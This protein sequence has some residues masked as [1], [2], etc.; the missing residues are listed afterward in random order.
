MAKPKHIA[1]EDILSME[2]YAAIRK[3]KAREITEIKRSRR[4]AVGPD[5]TLYFESF[6]TMWRQVHEML[7]IER[8]GDDQLED[9]LSAYNPLIP[10]GNEL[11]ATLMFEIDDRARRQRVLGQMGGVEETVELRLGHEVIP[12]HAETD[13]DRTT[14]DGK[15]SSV[16]FLHFPFMPGQI[17]RFRDGSEQ[18]V[19]AITHPQYSHMA[20]MPDNVRQALAEDFD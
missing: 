18:V 3:D 8:G 14:A 13:V 2:E 5:A 20:V 10:Q 15:A 7:F 6:D 1:R 9:E 19:L 4:M 12:A 17:Q 16:H 11:V